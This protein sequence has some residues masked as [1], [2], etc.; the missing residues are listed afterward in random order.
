MYFSILLPVLVGVVGLILL[1][2]L[3]FFFVFHPIRASRDIFYS[4]RERETRRSFFLALAG[5]LGVGNIFGVAAGIMIGGG[6][7]LFW[8]FVSSFFSMVIKYAET[9]LVFSIPKGNVGMSAVVSSSFSRFGGRLASVYALLTVLLALFMGS[10]MQAGAVVD[11]ARS[12]SSINASLPLIAL[13]IFF[14]PCLFGGARK[15][16]SFTEIIIPMTTIIYIIM[17]ILTILV[18]WSKIPS[19]FFGIINSAF[20][21]EGVAGGGFAI[22]I[23]EGFARGILSNE[24]GVGTSALAHSRAKGRSPHIAGL[25]GILEVFFDTTLLCM[26]TGISILVS[27]EDT[28]VY[29]SPMSLVSSAFKSSI[30]NFSGYVLLFCI[31]SFA[32]STIICWY[33]YGIECASAYFPRLKPAYVFAFLLFIAIC[34]FLPSTLLL[35]LTDSILFVMAVITLFTI[36]RKLDIIVALSKE[37][38]GVNK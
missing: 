30:G 36:V 19:V 26:L 37:G 35:F 14:I 27:L 10:A 5:T 25:F 8:L 11:V 15:I 21:I 38:R 2:R 18:N 20:S 32:F 34:G 23:K 17:C 24:A 13:L 3:R 16:E 28:S 1:I 9:L 12:I 22:A 6:G 31:F 4:M 29:K 7:S 33:F